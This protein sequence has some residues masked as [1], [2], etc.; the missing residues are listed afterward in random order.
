MKNTNTFC[1]NCGEQ[2]TNTYCGHCGQRKTVGSITWKEIS[3][4][5]SDFVFSVN[6]PFF[7]TIKSLFS[8]PG[9]LFREFLAGKRRKYYKPVA[10]F[11]LMTVIYVITRKLLNFNPFA[12]V[13]E[14]KDIGD[15]MA[16][17]KEAGSFMFK[18][19]NNLLFIFVFTLG[20]SLKLFNYKKFRLI[21]FMAISFYVVSVYVIFAIINISLVSV[22]EVKFQF[23]AIL[24]MLTYFIWVCIDLFRSPKWLI[25]LKALLT[26]IL[27][28]CFYIAF[29]YALSVLIVWLN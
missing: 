15:E 10:F 17:F 26:Y 2:V 11:I 14:N 12:A 25:I 3:Q 13:S 4:D 9:S 7:T 8:A 29:S 23:L 21:E 18:N 5:F 6:A 19:I 20:L 28:M 1:N 16:L 24:L 22:F 27:A